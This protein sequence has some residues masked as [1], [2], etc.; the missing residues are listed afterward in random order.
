MPKLLE[1]ASGRW[2]RLVLLLVLIIS[3]FIVPAAV[4]GFLFEKAMMP[5]LRKGLPAAIAADRVKAH[6]AEYQAGVAVRNASLEGAAF[7]NVIAYMTNALWWSLIV[8]AL[9]VAVMIVGF[10]NPSRFDEWVRR[11]NEEGQFE[12]Q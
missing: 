2:A 12:S 4:F 1:L 9:L 5:A 8:V 11:R 6:Y 10:P 3:A 7:L